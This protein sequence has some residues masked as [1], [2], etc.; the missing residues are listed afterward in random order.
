MQRD[1]KYIVHRFG[2][3]EA[4]GRRIYYSIGHG[5]QPSRFSKAHNLGMEV[6]SPQRI[7]KVASESLH[8]GMRYPDAHARERRN[9]SNSSGFEE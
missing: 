7:R 9:D 6:S 5:Q 2:G 3:L 8:P 4:P 1:S